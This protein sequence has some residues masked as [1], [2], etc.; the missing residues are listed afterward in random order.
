MIAPRIQINLSLILN[1]L[2]TY[3][4][5]L[6]TT[7]LNRAIV[8]LLIHPYHDASTLRSLDVRSGLRCQSRL[9]ACFGSS[10]HNGTAF[11]QWG[12]ALLVPHQRRLQASNEVYGGNASNLDFV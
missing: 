7:V 10:V 2:T 5:T 12:P 4:I 8:A 6:A 9:W 1:V 3:P 11:D